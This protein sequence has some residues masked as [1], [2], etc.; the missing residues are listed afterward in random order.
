[1]EGLLSTG[2]TPSSFCMTKHIVVLLIMD[3]KEAKSDVNGWKG[4]VCLWLLCIKK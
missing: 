4:K 1:M 3:I 2:P